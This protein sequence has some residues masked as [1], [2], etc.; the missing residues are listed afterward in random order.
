MG[1]LDRGWEG[2]PE[3]KR[4]PKQPSAYQRRLYYDTVM[5]SEEGAAFSARRGRRRPRGARQRL[6]VRAVAPLA[7]GWLQNLKPL[8]Q[9]E[10]EKILWRNLES[11]LGL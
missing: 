5:G 8:T 7:G 3:D 11:L 2:M 1:R 10:K 9:D 6:A 4:T